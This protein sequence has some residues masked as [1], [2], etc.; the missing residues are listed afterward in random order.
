M[1][2]SGGDGA[3]FGL[4][5]AELV[6]VALQLKEQ[7]LEDSLV[8]LHCHVGS[9]LTDIRR[10]RAAVREAAQAYVDLQDL[11]AGCVT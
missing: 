4:T 10:I 7:G 6:D 3:K 1:G 9:Q 5:A 8:M 2:E 11:G